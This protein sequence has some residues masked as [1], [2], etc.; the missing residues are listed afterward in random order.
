MDYDDVLYISIV[1]FCVHEISWLVLNLFYLG[2][3]KYKL[4]QK[5]RITTNIID[6]NQQIMV[7]KELFLKHL[8]LLFPAQILSYPLLK[9]LKLTTDEQYMPALYHIMIQFIILNII[10]DFIFYWVHRA[11]HYPY[12]YKRIHSIHH[13]FDLMFGNT[14][15]LNG[16]YSHYIENI[17]NDFTP[18]MIGLYIW[19]F[20]GMTHVTVFWLWIFFRQLRTA[21]AHSGYDFPYHPLKLINFVYGGTRIHSFHHTLAGRKHNFGGLIIWD[22]MFGTEYNGMLINH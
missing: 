17:L 3:D 12:L 21:D 1:T 8:I 2:L 6:I 4:F 22:R 15:S 13:K 19:S 7:F 18:M 10:E 14:F 9:Y 5:Y 16:E 11:L 20:I